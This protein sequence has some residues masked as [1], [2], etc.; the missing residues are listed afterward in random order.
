MCH[1][2][3]SHVMM[4]ADERGLGDKVHNPL[5]PSPPKRRWVTFATLDHTHTNIYIYIL[6]H[7]ARS[8]VLHTYNTVCACLPPCD[9][10]RRPSTYLPTY[11]HTT[12][13][14]AQMSWPRR[15]VWRPAAT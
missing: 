9:V 4:F 3:P 14:K 5:P 12:Q 15:R 13:A 7:K 10:S 11:A 6:A 8:G 1:Q 2:T